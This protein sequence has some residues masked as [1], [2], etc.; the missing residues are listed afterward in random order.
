MLNTLK[1]FCIKCIKI[2]VLSFLA[3]FKKETT[4]FFVLLITCFSGWSQ[5]IEFK[6][7]DKKLSHSTVYDITKDED[8]IMWFAT[9]E[10]LN[11]YD[12]H[13]IKTYYSSKHKDSIQ[14]SLNNNEINCLLS[15]ENGLY[16][17]THSGLNL[18]DKSTSTF[19]KIKLGEG[20]SENIKVLYKTSGNNILVGTTKGLYVIDRFNGITTLRKKTFVQGICEYKTNVYLLAISQKILLIN[21]LGET[22]K[23]YSIKSLVEENI[24]FGVLT[25]FRDNIGKIWLGT[26]NGLY[27]FD[28]S[29]D[30][31]IRVPIKFN[32]KRIESNFVRRI[33]EDNDNNLW[34]GTG[35]GIYIYNKNT[36]TTKHYG[37]S[38]NKNSGK[39]SDK[40]IYALYYDDLG[41][42]WVGTYFGGINYTKPKGIG[43]SEM[44]PRQQTLSGKVVSD[45][46][47]DKNDNLWLGTED[48]G[49][50]IISDSS[51]PKFSY[52]STK[53][54][55]SSDNIHA[56]CEDYEGIMWIGTYLGGLNKYNPKTKTVKVF[57]RNETSKKSLSNNFVYSILEYSKDELWIGTQR[58]LN[59]Y[60]KKTGDFYLFKPNELNNKFIYDL[61][62]DNKGNIW[63][64]TRFSGIYK[65]NPQT[66]KLEHFTFGKNKDTIFSSNEFIS[67]YQDSNGDIWFGSL[68][69]GVLVYKETTNTFKSITQN[70]G[71]PNNNIYGA[72]EDKNNKIWLTSNKGLSQYNKETGQIVN[73]N[74]ENGLTTSQFNFKALYKDQKNRLY[75]GSI[76]GLNYFHPDSLSVNTN[77]PK[78]KLTNFKLF[79]KEVPISKNGVLNKDIDLTKKI[80]L[81]HTQNVITFEFTTLDFDSN[82]SNNYEYYLEPFEENWN[83]VNNKHSATYTNLSPG[84]YTF[85]VRTQANDKSTNE[86][87]VI[88]TITPPF[89]KS[90]WAYA[91]YSLLILLSIYIYTR[92]VNVMHKQRM[93]VELER[94][95]KDKISELSKHKL[96]FFTFISHEF[97]TPLTIIIASIERY[98]QNNKYNNQT[99][100]KELI[101]IKQNSIKLNHLIKQLME[102]RKI[103]T[104][105]SKLQLKRGDII[106]CIKKN[107]EVFQPM[108]DNKKINYKVKSSFSE[109]ICFFDVDKL[110]MILTNLISNAIKNTPES[111]KIELYSTI[112]NT[113]DKEGKSHITI[114]VKDTGVG[115][116]SEKI[117]KILNPFYHSTGSNN[118]E[119]SGIGLTLVNS[120]TNFLGGS[121]SINSEEGLGT[122]IQVTIPLL[123]KLN[124]SSNE[125][126]EYKETDLPKIGIEHLRDEIDYNELKDNYDGKLSNQLRMLIVDDNKELLN[127]LKKYFSNKYKVSCANDG[128]QAMMKIEKRTPDIIISDIRMPK[129]NGFT[130]CKKIKSDPKTS[131]VPF[132]LLSGKS[133]ES[134]RLEGLGLGANAYINKPFNIEELSLL[135]K[136]LLS[137][138]SHIETKFTNLFTDKSPVK[139]S[140]N[141]EREF[142]KRIKDIVENN[143]SNSNFTIEHLATK[144]GIS[145]TLIHIKLKKVLNKN[146]SE[147]VK[148]YRLKIALSLLQQ[149][150]SISEAAYK[151]GYNDPN[152]FGRVFKKEFKMTPSEYLEKNR[153]EDIKNQ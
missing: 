68:K 132:L 97:K 23:D 1:F 4:L 37:Q 75:F 43:F 91:I 83:K 61:L 16:V 19:K 119:G 139:A 104:D 134:D 121:L 124:L 51:P 15:S 114:S 39:L 7:L 66:D 65:Y 137:T 110:E 116:S 35:Y 95:E 138:S 48:N 42:M 32:K 71:L 58:G 98:F 122:T 106:Q 40:S 62:R 79:N 126:L 152:Y 54:G 12:S 93:A 30:E 3:I 92:I 130:L 150:F 151:T 89:W 101:S 14:T 135:V 80:T 69:G 9:R 38:Y 148:D 96:T 125:I 50:T 52:L 36:K 149:G 47:Q 10:G 141:Q 142:L 60:S 81:N 44:L 82:S 86:R 25:L 70:D 45:I 74:E 11:S 111:K 94:M 57:K 143:Y 29:K 85:R 140:N 6:E 128:V 145:R 72:V 41:I 103:E 24:N 120:L 18:F 2:D 8:G 56:L 115:M 78:I 105:H 26:V 117:K 133:D 21:N 64:C 63:I 5:S 153:M 55:L 33:A 46:I 28:E 99:P 118:Y 59:I 129:M 102:F 27:Y 53:Q 109:Y 73:F 147:Y 112:T 77:I 108:L 87:S 34:L 131:H 136:N 88:L 20:N 67:A 146:A 49:I 22:I 13:S 76:Y 17:G 84:E 123:L 100:P 127:L 107:F 113:L 31:F 144:M 90:N